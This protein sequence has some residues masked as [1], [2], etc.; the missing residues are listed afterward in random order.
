VND[1]EIATALAAFHTWWRRVA[2]RGGFSTTALSTL[3]TLDRTGPQRIS[4]LAARERITQPG[5]TGLVTRLADEGLVERV[6]DTA[7]GRVIRAAITEVGRVRLAAL[8]AER[9]EQLADLVGL[10]GTADRH[11]L[12]AAVP[13]LDRLAA[14]SEQEVAA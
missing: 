4:D 13:A 3:D 2:D 1:S 5:M 14:L 8:R 7:D 11:A 6:Q 10:L 9:R 12:A